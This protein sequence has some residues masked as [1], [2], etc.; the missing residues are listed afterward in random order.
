MIVTDQL[1]QEDRVQADWEQSTWQD[2]VWGGT[3]DPVAWGRNTGLGA[4][5]QR[6]FC[7]RQSA[8]GR[9]F[10]PL[11]QSTALL[12][13]PSPQGR[14]LGREQGDQGEADHWAWGREPILTFLLRIGQLAK[15]ARGCRFTG[16]G[17]RVLTDY[18]CLVL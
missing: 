16:R 8:S 5:S 2:S 7:T 11:P 3:G 4:D 13:T 9:V 10:P 18:P 6:C 15:L 1:P 17:Q 14:P 12:L